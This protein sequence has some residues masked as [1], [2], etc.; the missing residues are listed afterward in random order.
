MKMIKGCL[1]PNCEHGKRKKK[2]VADDEINTLKKTYKYNDNF[3]SRCG[4]KLSYVCKVCNKS[5]STD[6]ADICE[7]CKAVKADKKD[8]RARNATIAVSA[9]GTVVTATPQVIKAIGKF[10]IKK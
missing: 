2:K 6:S 8:N 1:N 3:C 4:E 5:L 10:T 9:V 7:R